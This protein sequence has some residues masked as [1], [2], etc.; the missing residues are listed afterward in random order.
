MGTTNASVLPEPVLAMP[1]QSRPDIMIGRHCACTARGSAHLFFSI[2][3]RIRSANPHCEKL[4]TGFLLKKIYFQAE[5]RA[6][7]E[8]KIELK[9]HGTSFPLTLI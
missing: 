5:N 6:K 9:A 3:A 8:L 1:M 4:F 7:I 2:T